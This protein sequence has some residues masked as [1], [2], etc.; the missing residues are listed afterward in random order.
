METPK[1]N[2]DSNKPR[3]IDELA[4][5]TYGWLGRSFV[6]IR[7]T[8]IKTWQGVFVIA[9]CAGIAAATVLIVSFNIQQK[10]QAASQA[11]LSFS[12]ASVSVQKDAT[13]DL[14]VVLN[15][16]SSNVVAVKAIVN[17]NTSYA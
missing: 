10:S 11:T 15:T 9:F 8:R 4:K 5:K 16:D 2:N 14:N 12:P 1:N 3:P 6:F 17:Y 13:F 7:T